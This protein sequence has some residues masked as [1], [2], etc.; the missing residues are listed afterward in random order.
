MFC[1][2]FQT[3]RFL[4]LPVQS[5]IHW[6]N[7]WLFSFPLKCCQ[8]KI[9]THSFPS[10]WEG[11]LALCDQLPPFLAPIKR[12]MKKKKTSMPAQH[13]IVRLSAPPL[14]AKGSRLKETLVTCLQRAFCGTRD[15]W[16]HANPADLVSAWLL[17]WRQLL[18]SHQSHSCLFLHVLGLSLHPVIFEYVL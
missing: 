17:T 12:K 15:I 14:S 18:S 4:P 3:F 13:L 5:Q 2:N 8:K 16:A 10:R 9:L 6:K 11:H 7:Y 1:F